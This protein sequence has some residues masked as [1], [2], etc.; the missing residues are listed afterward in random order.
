MKVNLDMLESQKLVGKFKLIELLERQSPY[1]GFKTR[2]ERRFSQAISYFP[3]EYQEAALSLFGTTFYIP[4]MMMADTWK[5]LWQ[6]FTEK[7]GRRLSVE[8]FLILELDRDQLR[9]GFYR[10]NA[11]IGRLQDNLPIRSSS[12]I[13]DALMQ[14]GNGNTNPELS[15]AIRGMLSKQYWLLLMDLSISG[16]SGFTEINRLKEIRSLFFPDRSIKFIALIQIATDRALEILNRTESDI[17]SA[18]TI[19]ESCA[20]NSQF[21]DLITDDDL[22][23]SM[24]ELCKWFGEEVILPSQSRLSLI[25]EK[26][27][28]LDILYYG[29]GGMGWNIVTHRNTPNNSL[30]LLWFAHQSSDYRPPFERVDSRTTASWAGRKEWLRRVKTDDDHRTTVMDAISK[31][32]LGV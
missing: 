23:L 10:S 20:L 3:G 29:F 7:V 30:P 17:I 21:Y 28:N 5:Y 9:D 13:I 24:R 15:S 22:I 18:I 14:I 25:S 8:E 12:D 11:I 6:V 31:L 32:R 4:E 1:R 2:V 16:S 26:A 27:E 19:P